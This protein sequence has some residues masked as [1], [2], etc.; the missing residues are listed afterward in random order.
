MWASILATTASSHAPSNTGR[1][2]IDY[3]NATYYAARYE[4]ARGYFD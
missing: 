2:R 4:T 3:L 1:V